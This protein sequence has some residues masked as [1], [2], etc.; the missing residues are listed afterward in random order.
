[1]EID[2]L[3]NWSSLLVFFWPLEL[4]IASIHIAYWAFHMISSFSGMTTS[5]VGCG[6]QEV[7]ACQIGLWSVVWVNTRSVVVPCL[8]LT[9]NPRLFLNSN[10]AGLHNWRYLFVNFLGNSLWLY[11]FLPFVLSCFVVRVH[12]LQF[13]DL[14]VYS[15]SQRNPFFHRFWFGM[16]CLI[17]RLGKLLILKLRAYCTI[18][19]GLGDRF[20]LAL[21]F[22]SFL[23][24][25][26]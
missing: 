8:N 20:C 13:G 3:Q 6:R 19:R 23:A 14:L 15:W 10:F 25:G 11:H 26:L 5:R 16:F 21:W 12:L 24:L 4:E 1:M 22:F 17:R 18:N 2:R 9:I 7:V